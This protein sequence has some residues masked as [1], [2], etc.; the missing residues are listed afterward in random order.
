MPTCIYTTIYNYF[1]LRVY[2]TPL[3]PL[4]ALR[5]NGAK[6]QYHSPRTLDFLTPIRSLAVLTV[7]MMNPC[8]S[9]FDD[10]PRRVSAYARQYSVNGLTFR[11]E[12]LN[13]S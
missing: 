12:K 7:L 3:G 1:V 4:R 11:F 2:C 9:D 8:G 5:P 6:S 13:G 10:V